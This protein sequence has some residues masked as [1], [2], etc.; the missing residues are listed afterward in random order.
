MHLQNYV[1]FKDAYKINKL[2]TIFSLN[3]ISFSCNQVPLRTDA[4]ISFFVEAES[5]Y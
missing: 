2:N 4:D 5:D 1:I 3:I